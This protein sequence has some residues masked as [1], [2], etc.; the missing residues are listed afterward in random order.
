MRRSKRYRTVLESPL[1]ALGKSN[2]MFQEPSLGTLIDCGLL[3]VQ[4]QRR[5]RR[6]VGLKFCFQ[7]Y[8]P[9]NYNPRIRVE[10]RAHGR[11]PT[12]RVLDL[13]LRSCVD[14]YLLN[15]SAF[16]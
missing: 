3:Q 15:E 14:Y 7:E 16:W 8:K 13:L 11:H 9:P 2:N 12:H 10:G 5:H 6:G 1:E 4:F